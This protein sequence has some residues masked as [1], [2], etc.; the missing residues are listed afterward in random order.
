M[1]VVCGKKAPTGSLLYAAAAGAGGGGDGAAA[2]GVTCC[3][4]LPCSEI[5]AINTPCWLPDAMETGF[6]DANVQ[7]EI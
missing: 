3:K 2:A 1:D 4:E 5:W 7:L 6:S